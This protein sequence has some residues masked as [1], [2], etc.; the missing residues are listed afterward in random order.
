[1]VQL[2]ELFSNEGGGIAGPETPG[3]ILARM[4]TPDDFLGFKPLPGGWTQQGDRWG[5]RWGLRWAGREIAS[6]QP[7]ADGVRV[8]L[9]CRKLWQVKEVRA[10]SIAQGKRYAERWC[11][12]R[13]LPELPLREAVARLGKKDEPP[14]PP[15]RPALTRTEMQQQRRFDAIPLPKL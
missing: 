15:P 1:M 13:V 7:D 5:L 9:S 12:A 4:N 14:P 6:V 11:A 2:P 8:V 10:A 3:R